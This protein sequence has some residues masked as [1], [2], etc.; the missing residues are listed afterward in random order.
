MACTIWPALLKTILTNALS[1]VLLVIADDGVDSL[2]TSLGD[3]LNDVAEVVDK[4]VELCVALSDGS[5]EAVHNTDNAFNNSD[6][7]L[8]LCLNVG[9]G[10]ID[11]FN[12][13][14]N[15]CIELDELCNVCVEVDVCVQIVDIELNA[16]DREL[17]N[18]EMDIWR[19]LR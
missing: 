1:H 9:N 11:L 17:R 2:A 18:L 3:L 13:N 8:K 7:Q 16:A 12:S 6:D 4:E 5:E 19:T 10:D 14:L 15:A